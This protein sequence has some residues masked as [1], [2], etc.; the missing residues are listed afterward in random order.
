MPAQGDSRPE[1]AGEVHSDGKDEIQAQKLEW[2]E[3]RLDD[4]VEDFF[5]Q[6]V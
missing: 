1:I 5:G 3:L 6:E 4:W 2:T